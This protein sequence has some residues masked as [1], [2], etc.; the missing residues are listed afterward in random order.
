MTELNT[1]ATPISAASWAQD[2][3]QIATRADALG[4]CRP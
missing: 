2:L 3:Q 1:V 4:V